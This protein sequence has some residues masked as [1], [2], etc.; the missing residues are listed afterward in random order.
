MVQC[1]GRESVLQL[2]RQFPTT[3]GTRASVPTI[4]NHERDV[5]TKARE[6]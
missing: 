5:K 3:Q 1:R 2:R 6:I 4:C